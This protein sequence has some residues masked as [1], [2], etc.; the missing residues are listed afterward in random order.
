MFVSLLCLFQSFLEGLHPRE[1]TRVPEGNI[2]I[3]QEAFMMEIEEGLCHLGIVGAWRSSAGLNFEDEFLTSTFSGS[4][5]RII[6]S[7]Y[8]FCLQICWCCWT[9][10]NVFLSQLYRARLF[11]R[12][13]AWF[14][15]FQTLLTS[16]PKNSFFWIK[17]F[18]ILTDNNNNNR[19]SN[20]VFSFFFF[21]WHKYFSVE[22][23][24]E[25][26]TL[27]SMLVSP[28]ITNTA[29]RHFVIKSVFWKTE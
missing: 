2:K 22:G 13:G 9:L 19:V 18:Q 7:F 1:V 20:T 24:V 23:L 3:I 29:P 4:S 6:L 27:S 15:L 26:R 12:D 5:L 10:A 21:S 8:T 17:L 16:A 11:I 28:S 25:K 14:S